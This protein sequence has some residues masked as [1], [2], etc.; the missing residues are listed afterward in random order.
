MHLKNIFNDIHQTLEASTTSLFIFQFYLGGKVL[1][2]ELRRALADGS[3]TQLLELKAFSVGPN[4]QPS[5]IISIIVRRYLQSPSK[6]YMINNIAIGQQI[7]SI[8]K[9][10]QNYHN[11]NLRRN[12][13]MGDRETFND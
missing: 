3:F 13:N 5:Q 10:G 4:F 9:V 7:S 8:Y 2:A 1:Q 12:Q 11:F 6:I